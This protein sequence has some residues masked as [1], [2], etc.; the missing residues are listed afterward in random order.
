[1]IPNILIIGEPGSGKSVGSAADALAFRGAKV[2]LD[3]HKDSLARMVL[4][5]ANGNILYDRLDDLDHPLGYGLLRAS[6]HQNPLKRQ[7]EN[8]RRAKLFVEVMMRRRGGDIAGTPL[9][10]EWIMA[11]LMLF[12]YQR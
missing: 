10:E 1:M 5:H 6:E 7:Q 3:P 11:L 9:M 8:Q 2:I 12:L 4:T